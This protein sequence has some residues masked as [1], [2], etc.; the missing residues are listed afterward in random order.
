MV[1]DARGNA[2]GIGDVKIGQFEMPDK[3]LRPAIPDEFDALEAVF[4]S[5]GQDDGYYEKLKNLGDKILRRVLTGLRDIAADEELFNQ[6]IKENVTTESLL[7]Y[8]TRVAVQGQFRRL[9]K[10]GARLSKYH[11]QY[12]TPIHKDSSADPI[13]LTFH[14]EPESHPPSNIHVLIG[15]N[16]VGKT[17]LLNSMMRALIDDTAIP[18][19]VGRFA[20][21]EK[22]QGELFANLV[23]VNF[24][25][26]DPFEPPPE[27]YGNKEE[28]Q[29]SYVGLKRTSNTGPGLGTPK[30]PEMLTKE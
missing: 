6:A 10:G 24:S 15:R 8:V 22:V 1:Y 20:S 27:R 13:D 17:H 3:A 18:R 19:E 28:M 14:V 30:S 4:F 12:T 23:S 9:A 11:F 29:Y 5:L 25:A 2:H 16:G 21:E 7:R 26:F